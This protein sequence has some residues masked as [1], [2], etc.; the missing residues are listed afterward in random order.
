V[1]EI[2]TEKVKKKKIWKKLNKVVGSKKN[3]IIILKF[4]A[5]LYSPVSINNIFISINSTTKAMQKN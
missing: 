3:T 2:N 1:S 5:N 4:V